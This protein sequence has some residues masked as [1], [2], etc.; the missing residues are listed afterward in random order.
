M[1]PRRRAAPVGVGALLAL[2]FLGGSQALGAVVPVSPSPQQTPPLT[3]TGDSAPLNL[4]PPPAV[5]G[6]A[7][8]TVSTPVGTATT[9]AGSSASPVRATGAGSV[10]IPAVVLAAYR[11]AEASVAVTTPGCHLGWTLLAAI[12]QV[13]SGQAEGGD[14]SANGT[15]LHPILGPLLDGSSGTAAIRDASGSW[16]RAQGPMQFLPSTW[17]AWGADGNGDGV[18]DPNNVFDAALAAGHYLCAGSRDLNQSADLRRAILS[19]N[20]SDTYVNT[21]LA[22]MSYYQHSVV[23]GVAPATPSATPTAT[24]TA[25]ATTAPPSSAGASATPSATASPTPRPSASASS[26]RPS[27]SPSPDPSASTSPSASGTPTP[28]G[29][30]TPSATPTSP[31]GCP[32]TAT[33]TT[34]TPTPTPTPS[35]ST[36]STPPA[37]ACPSPTPTPTASPSTAVPTASSTP[38]V[39]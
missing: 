18:A 34:G 32:T 20:H 31:T 28:T 14:V 11:R 38:A 29:T 4:A 9:A 24:A 10:G 22:W 12:G 35:T 23:T 2:V 6:T 33:P 16:A 37:T 39:Q 17:A 15:T 19:Y 3:A 21:V 13:E 1:G 5:S 30:P 8:F 36:T 25:A 26:G 27:A 7:Q